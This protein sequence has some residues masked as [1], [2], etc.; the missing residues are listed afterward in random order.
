M[1]YMIRSLTKSATTVGMLNVA[2]VVAWL[3]PVTTW[4]IAA[5]FILSYSYSLLTGAARWL[6]HRAD[7][8]PPETTT[9]GELD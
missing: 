5:S 6:K 4:P 8:A 1:P 7:D 2:L 3:V 9:S